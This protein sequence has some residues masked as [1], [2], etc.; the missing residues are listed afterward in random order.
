[1]DGKAA[2]TR[3]FKS[4]SS[5]GSIDLAAVIRSHGLLGSTAITP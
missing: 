1:L 5:T 3:R 4:L 2:E